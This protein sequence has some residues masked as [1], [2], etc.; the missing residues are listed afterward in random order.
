MLEVAWPPMLAC[1]SLPMEDSDDERTVAMCLQ[2]RVAPGTS[3]LTASRPVL[4]VGLSGL[5]WGW[6]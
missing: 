4:R 6:G 2:V 3:Q 5:R 1:F